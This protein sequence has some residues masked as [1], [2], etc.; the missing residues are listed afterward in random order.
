MGRKELCF[1]HMARATT[2]VGPLKWRKH[3]VL[4]CKTASVRLLIVGTQPSV[5]DMVADHA[6]ASLQP[7]AFS[8]M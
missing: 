4:L 1:S 6:G 2:A 3:M 5:I 7:L 8:L